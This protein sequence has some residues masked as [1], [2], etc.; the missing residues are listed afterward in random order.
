MAVRVNLTGRVQGVGF[1]A[2]TQAGAR[3]LG[4]TGWVRNERDGSITAL[5]AG[6]Q[7]A[8]EAMLQRLHEG[9]PAARV[10]DVRVEDAEPGARPSGFLVTG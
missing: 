10:T 6:R 2:W 4:L 5:L 7:E 9:P 3:K 1:R 8:V